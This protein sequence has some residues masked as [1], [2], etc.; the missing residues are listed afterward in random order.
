MIDFP[1]ETERQVSIVNFGQTEKGKID[2]KY[3]IGI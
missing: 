3:S 1:A 2:C